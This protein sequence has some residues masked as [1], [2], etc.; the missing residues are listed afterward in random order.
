MSRAKAAFR[1]VSTFPLVMTVC[2]PELSMQQN[3]IYILAEQKTYLL[4]SSLEGAA[5]IFM[6]R[7]ARHIQALQY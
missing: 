5:E 7:R 3:R 6:K 4:F 2:T 1:P